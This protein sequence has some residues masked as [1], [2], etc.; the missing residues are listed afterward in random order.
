MP[1]REF[2]VGFCTPWS[3]DDGENDIINLMIYG[4]GGGT[5]FNGILRPDQAMEL[6]NQ[7]DLALT[8]VA[9]ARARIPVYVVVDNAGYEG[10][11]DL[12]EARTY[13]EALRWRRDNYDG[14]V[15]A[16]RHIEIARDIAG[17]RSYEL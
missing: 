9:D 3:V 5:R 14:D 8:K 1:V 12:H 15:I 11:R 17:Q 6:R 2:A 16:E 10:E 13:D 7:L 4:P